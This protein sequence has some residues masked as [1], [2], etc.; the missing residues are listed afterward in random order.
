M[1]IGV[2][3]AWFLAVFAVAG[4]GEICGTN[5][6]ETT[7]LKN[8]TGQLLSIE[9]C[10]IPDKLISGPADD[11]TEV[12]SKVGIFEIKPAQEGNF[13]TDDYQIS[14]KK[15]SGKDCP[16]VPNPP[17]SYSSQV[18]LTSKSIFQYTLCRNNTDPTI[19]AL[20]PLGS[21]CPAGSTAQAAAVTNCNSTS[22]IAH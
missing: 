8:T 13:T 6:P 15:E 3:S 2:V 4:C 14:S 18:F 17:P 1:R 19:A 16:A 20:A 7:Q 10:A 5:V 22:L 21:A 11:K 9:L 12:K